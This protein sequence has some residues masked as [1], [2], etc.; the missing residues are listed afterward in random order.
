M[1]AHD[2]HE[3][4][5]LKKAAETDV[6][7][8]GAGFAGLSAAYELAR[9]GV[10]VVVLEAEHDVGGLA[11]GFEVGGRNLDRFYHHWFTS[12]KEVLELVQELGL[13]DKVIVRPTRTGTYCGGRIWNL[14]TP[15]ELLRFSPLC[16]VDRIRLGLL[17]IQ[18]RR[19]R[20]WMSLEHLTA[21]EWL[22]GMC[23]E[24]VFRVVWE[25]L[26]RGKFGRHADAIS[27]V[28]IWNK[29]KLRAGSRG[30]KGEEQLAYFQGG[31]LAL[32]HALEER[33]RFE[34]GRILF[35]SGVQAIEPIG[36]KWRVSTAKS[37]FTAGH[38]LVTTSL[39]L[40]SRMIGSWAPRDYIDTLDRL[41]YLANVCLVLELDRP[42]S[43]TYWLNVNDAD[44]PFVGV[45]EHTNFIP[46]SEYGGRHV[47]YLT[48][49]L[50]ESDPVFLMSADEITQCVMP[51]LRNMFPGF[52]PGWI[53]DRHLWKARWSQPVVE[54]G[55][56]ALIPAE[57]GP[58]PGLHLCTMA[59]V[60]PEDR[61]TNYAVRQ[62]RNAG[63]RI[64][65][66]CSKKN[67]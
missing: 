57:S 67:S 23:G 64:A 54:K 24:R 58:L 46:A 7:V 30:R 48:K 22:I 19:V 39:P 18:A 65:E 37:V 17:V 55:F 14:S 47:V 45:I 33:I 1:K 2:F 42:L 16:L 49:Y 15:L 36:G 62:G 59:Q 25:P 63:R 3:E 32:A 11:A 34:K 51:H 13:Q 66:S 29:L 28:W 53:L 12:D 8:V 4:H 20:D 31:F 43:E 61:G 44:V 52:D 6:V 21:R 27:A 38:V 50:E 10:G 9:Q 26:L 56:S 35:D 41:R 60:Y 40:F 5:G